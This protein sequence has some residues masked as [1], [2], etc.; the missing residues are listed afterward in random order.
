MKKANKVSVK[1]VVLLA[2][3]STLLLLIVSCC[4]MT[5]NSEGFYTYE[6]QDEIKTIFKENIDEFDQYVEM[7]RYHDM[8]RKYFDDT[9][10]ADYTSYKIFKE[11]T[12]EEEY[13][14][15]EQFGKKYHPWFWYPYG[16]LLDYDGGYFSICKYKEG[17]NNKVVDFK[18]YR[19]K[20]D[21][22]T[23]E[24]YEDWV[25]ITG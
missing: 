11:Y 7:F 19:A 12:T 5:H 17:E 1:R 16:I 25:F 14:F 24:Y 20:E 9:H 23:V 18:I 6:S 4:I 8:W 3:F 15:L 13:H 21:G 10:I 2:I 22:Y